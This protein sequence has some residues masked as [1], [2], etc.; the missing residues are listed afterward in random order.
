MES[1][2]AHDHSRCITSARA[3][4]EERCAAQGLRLTDS[5][6][7]VLDILLREHRAVGA[8]EILEQLA[9]EG[10]KAQPP[11]AYRALDFLVSHG[12][13]HKIEKLNAYIAC[14]TPG[15]VHSPAFM[16]CRNC[17]A[18]AE[19]TAETADSGLGA[20]ARTAG[21]AIEQTVIEAEGLCPACRHEG[22]A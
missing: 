19:A 1:F 7:R 22:A 16:I 13:A 10:H 17:N 6:R 14:T 12:F 15:E 5:R 11:V 3:A 2:S 21:F 8:Y 4:I 9:A 20:L 18:I